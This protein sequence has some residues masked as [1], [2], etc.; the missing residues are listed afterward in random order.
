MDKTFPIEPTSDEAASMYAEIEACLKEIE[1]LRTR[2]HQEQSEIE[3]S[4]MRTRAM[5]ARLQAE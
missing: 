3:K 2:M 4:R 1:Q 5:L